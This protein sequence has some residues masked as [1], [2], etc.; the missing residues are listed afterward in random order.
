MLETRPRQ[1]TIA[2]RRYELSPVNVHE[3]MRGLQPDPLQAH[4]VVVGGRRFPPKQVIAE[5]T[6][7]DRADF[8]THQARRILA[9]LGFPVGRRPGAGHIA[10]S[11]DE[12]APEPETEA[13]FAPLV[14][15]WVAMRG[16]EILV[17]AAR[18]EDVVSWLARHGQKADTMFRVPD[19]EAAATGIAPL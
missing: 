13:P 17:S 9:N 12:T 14:G 1:F 2:R 11:R 7:L 3:T 8:T 5:V 16:D 6:G 10:R 15:E 4:F 19:D 18:P